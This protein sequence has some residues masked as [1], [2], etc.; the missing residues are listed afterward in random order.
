MRWSSAFIPT[1]RHDPA[2][3]DAA[4]HRLLLRAGFIRQRGVGLYSYLPLARRSFAK[5]EAILREEMTAI[6]AANLE[7]ARSGVAAAEPE[8]EDKAA[9]QPFPTPGVRT[10]DDRARMP[11]GAAADRPIKTPVWRAACPAA[12][13]SW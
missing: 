7:K 13:W 3:A 1:F 2:G 4:S 5:I 11:G 8:G 6:G 10:I 9:P 12:R